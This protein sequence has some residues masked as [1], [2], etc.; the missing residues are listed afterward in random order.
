[1][2]LI[3]LLVL[4]FTCF[5]IPQSASA[6]GVT[7]AAMS[8]FV[9]DEAGEALPGA[10]IQAR[11]VPTGTEYAAITR[12]NGAY[13]IFNMRVGGPYTVTARFV[14]FE[15]QE[16]PD[17]FLRLG[18]T[19]RIDFQLAVQNVELDE[20]QVTAELDA[21]LNPDR[22]GAATSVDPDQVTRMPS[23][24]RS[25][26]DLTR[27]DP[28]SDGNFSFGGRNWLFNNVSLD[29]SYF[30]N[31]FGLDDPAPGGQTGAEPVPFDAV[32]QVQVSVAPFDVREGGFT[33]ANINTVTKSGTNEFKASA[34]SYF[35]NE[36]LQ[37]NTVSGTEVVANPDL[38]FNQSGLT[39][40]G[41]IIKDKLFFFANGEL[42]RRD[43]P[44]TNFA[45]S[46][47]GGAGPGVSRVEASVLNQIRQR[48]INAY[49]Y[50]PGAFEDYINETNNNKLLAKLN[51]NISTAHNLSFRYNYLDAE[52]DLPPHPFALSFNG[53]GRGP[54]QN[55]LPYQN[56][57][58]TINNKLHSFAL[59]VNSRGSAWANR[60]FASYNRFRDFRTPNSEPF[61][62]I[63]IGEDG[64]TYTTVG[65]EPFSIHNILDQNVFQITNNFTYFRG[66]HVL[67]G[68]VNF[69]TFSFFNSFNIFRHGLFGFGFAP[70][71]FASVDAFM[72]ATDP[73]NPDQIDFRSFITPE[74]APFKGEDISV[75][76]LGVY[77][78]DEF[79]FSPQFNV[80]LG[81]RVDFPIYF[82]DPVD[83]PFSRGL[84]A[85]DENDNPET[86]DQS[87]LPDPTPLLSPRLGF[88]WDVTG[89]RSTQVRGG[90]GIFTG[91][92][93]FVWYGNAISNPGNNPNLFPNIPLDQVPEDQ[94]TQDNS[95]LQTAFDVNALDPDF[96]WP[97][98]W[99]TDLAIDQQ[100]PWDLLGTLEVIYGKD[101]NA[102]YIR[103]ADLAAPVRTL[104][105]DGRRYFGADQ[106]ANELNSDGGAG[107][108]VLDNTDEGYNLNVTAQLRKFFEFG[109]STSLS[110]S[111]TEAKNQMKST[112]I[113]SALWQ[114]IAVQGDP[115]NPDLSY[116]EFGHRN[117][118]VGTA[119]YRHSWSERFATSFGLFLEVADGNQFS[120]AG[121]NRYSFTYSGD[122]NG[123]GSA[124]NDLIYIPS[125][126][127]EINFAPFT[128]GSG[129]TVSAQ[130]QWDRFN[131]FIEQDDYLSA[132]RGEI[133]ERFG[134]L[135]PWYS[136]IDLRILQDVVF[137]VSGKRQTVQ[138]SLDILNVANLLNSDWGVRQVASAAA[139]SPLTFTGA[140]NNNGAPLFNF[141]GPSATF[142]DDPGILSRWRMQFGIKYLF[143]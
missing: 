87:V 128:D 91:R 19:S 131:A 11:H 141:T 119:N 64:V 65:H 54:N 49:N 18:E 94:M 81:L 27:L 106:G 33:G 2:P 46:T 99:N 134:A 100:L 45:A 32:E 3:G 71:T 40:S 37:G 124:A 129:N 29:G 73:N 39:L 127:S 135:N 102:I 42:E 98:V 50:D 1:R 111:F 41:P 5:L 44:G 76:Q 28:R 79:L 104:P 12:A 55:S 17:I 110:Y 132:H 101:L 38:S 22:T 77:A 121:G 113:A 103:N 78:Q 122:V 80:T 83:N 120:G 89:D 63:E 59:E 4:L 115:N 109:L 123:D 140:F 23:I 43:D 75:G 47:G 117:R 70:T 25:T 66:R 10:T 90:T 142:I 88:N 97:Q 116:S 92:I 7:T 51:W 61:P 107:I 69:E 93:P 74:S 130:E 13:N 68:G 126:Q 72:A 21:V 139:T 6:Q 114:E 105:I 56:A 143:N 125:D 133:A 48:M 85:L 67:T 60:F 138:L 30:N 34:Y 112:E 137:N 118:I 52:R 14:G 26:R 84:T 16:Q 95:I 24:K 62:T 36:S 82:T 35:R 86:V 8:G 53:T 96:V 9:T 108:Y 57:G 15:P 20:I 58:Y 136:N 31:P